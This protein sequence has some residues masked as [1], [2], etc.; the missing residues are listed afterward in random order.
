MAC[1][2]D[3]TGLPSP[4]SPWVDRGREQASNSVAGVFGYGHGVGYAYT[5]YSF[6][7]VLVPVR[8]A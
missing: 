7:Q 6:R 5:Y 1:Y 2:S 3:G 4:V 8:N